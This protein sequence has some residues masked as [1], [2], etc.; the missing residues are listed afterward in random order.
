MI[1]NTSGSG[2]LQW[3]SGFW[4]WQTQSFHQFGFPAQELHKPIPI[5]NSAQKVER[6]TRF[7]P[8]DKKLHAGGC[9][10]MTKKKKNVF[11]IDKI[12]I[13]PDPMSIKAPTIELYRLYN[14]EEETKN[15]RGEIQISSCNIVWEGWISSKCIVLMYD[16]LKK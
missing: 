6:V 14:N 8:L 7:L 9:C 16:F 12:G 1:L 13:S 15:L 3:K 4:T 5:K 2:G 11:F 10:W